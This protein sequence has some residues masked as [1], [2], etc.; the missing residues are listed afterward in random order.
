MSEDR[1]GRRLLGWLIAVAIR[2]LTASVRCTV[3]GREAVD[4]VL[5]QDGRLIY[6]FW[7]GR[8]AVLLKMHEGEH[9]VIMVSLSTDGTLQKAVVEH[10][11]YDTVRGSSSR[12]G[13]VALLELK[14]RIMDQRAIGGLAVDGPSGPR[15]QAKEGAATLAAKTGAHLVPLTA[16]YRHR[17]VLR[18][19]DRLQI[20][21]PFTR[22][23]MI[24]GPPIP[25][26]N[27]PEGKRAG[28][29]RLQRELEGA[30]RRAE[31]MA[32]R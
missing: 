6:S 16:A 32:G 19:W 25:V 15:E 12:R 3:V 30:T 8:Q 31:E 7:H 14:R 22:A 11:G 28:I 5:H 17:W 2:L 27:T 21:W 10:Y 1:L 4:G 24:Y 18:S 13:M 9:V 20:P 23:W 26:A 29:E